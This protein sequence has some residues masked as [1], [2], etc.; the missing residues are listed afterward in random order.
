MLC[1]LFHI[2]H[3]SPFRSIKFYD[4]LLLCNT[5]FTA[6]LSADILLFTMKGT[7]DGIVRNAVLYYTKI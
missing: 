3:I 2:N 5:C 4:I 6:A 1:S 7:A